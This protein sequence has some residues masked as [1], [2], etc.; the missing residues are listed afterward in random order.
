[1]V[2][3]LYQSY[4]AW[5]DQVGCGAHDAHEFQAAFVAMCRSFGFSVDFDGAIARCFDLA[6]KSLGS[7]PEQ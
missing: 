6:M 3:D 2:A 1:V 5:C 4:R 7:Q